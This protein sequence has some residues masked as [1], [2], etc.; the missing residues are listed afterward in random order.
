MYIYLKNHL[1]THQQKFLLVPYFIIGLLVRH[2]L[3]YIL[4]G[5]TATIAKTSLKK[6]IRAVSHFTALVPSRSISLELANF[7]EVYFKE[8]YLRSER[9]NENSYV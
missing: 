4:G 3:D 6:W 9:E 7:S 1:A 2:N 5:T 8:T